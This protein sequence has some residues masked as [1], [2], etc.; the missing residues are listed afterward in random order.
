MQRRK[1]KI[2][3]D[4]AAMT[5]AIVRLAKQYG[6]YGDRR[7]RQLL[8]DEDWRVSVKRVY[9]IW[10]RDGLKVPQK[11]NPNAAV[12]GSMTDHVSGAIP[13]ACF[14]HDDPG[15]PTMSGAMTSC[16]TLPMVVAHVALRVLA[17]NVSDAP[18]AR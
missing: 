1:P 14:R 12:C 8:I 4:E 16:K 17:Y 10:R 3:D 9:R 15:G 18:A 13:K 5:E 6:R 11:C 2:R 7:V